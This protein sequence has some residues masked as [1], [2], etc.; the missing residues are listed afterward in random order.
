MIC[1][2]YFSRDFIDNTSYSRLYERMPRSK[3]SAVTHNAAASHASPR[4]RHASLVPP[5]IV[6]I[7]IDFSLITYWWWYSFNGRYYEYALWYYASQQP[8]TP[9]LCA[10]LWIPLSDWPTTVTYSCCQLPATCVLGA[11]IH[12]E[13]RTMMFST[14]ELLIIFIPR[15][16]YAKI[17]VCYRASRFWFITR[18]RFYNARNLMASAHNII[19]ECDYDTL[20]LAYSL[21]TIYWFRFRSRQ[22]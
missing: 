13:G 6:T 2:R 10:G 17:F 22:A 1:C 8:L 12:V 5:A 11:I 9:I 15:F 20:L 14:G 7:S 21:F 4:L 16:T 19:D 3:M 18:C